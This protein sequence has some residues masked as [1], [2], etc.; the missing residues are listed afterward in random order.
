MKPRVF[1]WAW[2]DH[3]PQLDPLMTPE[4]AARLL[5]AW[6][7]TARGAAR[8]RVLKRIGRGHYRV[9]DIRSGEVAEIMWRA[10]A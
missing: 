5:R 6:R 8:I 9:A 3:T 2:Q 1:Q 10:I 7:R 4:R